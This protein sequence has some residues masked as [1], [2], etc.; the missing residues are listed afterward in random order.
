MRSD[1][2]CGPPKSKR[3]AHTFSA[4]GPIGTV[5]TK[6][7]KD[8][9]MMT[10]QKT[11]ILAVLLLLTV[12]PIFWGCSAKEPS[13]AEQK[14]QLAGEP[15]KKFDPGS[16]PPQ[17]KEGFEKWQKGDHSKVSGPAIVTGPK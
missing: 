3:P 15:G 10:R 13:Q 2:M 5:C 16:V 8:N 4:G 14:R 12:L 7:N 9:S 6:Y 17:Y 11:P 1:P